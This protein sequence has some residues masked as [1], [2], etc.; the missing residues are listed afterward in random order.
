MAGWLK[1]ELKSGKKLS[2]FLIEQKAAPRSV[3][4]G[5]RKKK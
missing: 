2:D 4:K 1:A 3:K 5:H